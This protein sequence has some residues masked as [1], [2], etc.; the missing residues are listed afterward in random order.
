M[1]RPRTVKP[2][3]LRHEALGQAIKEVIRERKLTPDTVAAESGLAVEQLGTFMRGQGNPT[4]STLL[5]LCQGL[6]IELTDLHGRADK[7]LAERLNGS[8]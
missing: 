1:P 4:Y 7:L 5:K 6:H 8:A 3:S 2:R